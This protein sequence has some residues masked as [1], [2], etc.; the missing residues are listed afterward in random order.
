MIFVD[1]PPEKRKRRKADLA[2]V[3]AYLKRREEK[4][5]AEQNTPGEQNQLIVEA[6]QSQALPPPM[7]NV[8]PMLPATPAPMAA[9]G[10]DV[11]AAGVEQPSELPALIE[12]Q[13]TR[14]V[15][16]AAIPALH[17]Y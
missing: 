2:A 14:P 6:T 17:D 3:E 5:R 4:A 9:D 7:P 13:S 1:K 10:P 15:S 12:A 16:L 11:T 8:Q